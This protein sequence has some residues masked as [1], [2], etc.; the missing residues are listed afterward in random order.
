MA[1][2]KTAP[3][4]FKVKKFTGELPAVNGK[5]RIPSPFDDVVKASFDKDE[6]MLVECAKDDKLRAQIVAQLHKAAKFHGIGVD[7]WRTLDDGVAFKARAK[8]DVKPKA[9]S[10]AAAA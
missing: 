3:P 8:R 9:D 2:T 6:T 7:L 4:Q 5:E 1:E 10:A